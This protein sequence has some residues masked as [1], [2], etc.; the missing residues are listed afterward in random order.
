MSQITDAYSLA[1]EI[2]GQ[3]ADTMDAQIT[4]INRTETLHPRVRLMATRQLLPL[5]E[6]LKT[7]T[8]KLKAM[9]K[10]NIWEGE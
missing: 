2:I 4:N 9:A 6:Q 7:E 1:A 3:L 8:K 5:H 10:Q